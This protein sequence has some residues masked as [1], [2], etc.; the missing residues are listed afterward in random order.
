[1]PG[2]ACCPRACDGLVGWRGARKSGP[3]QGEAAFATL[4]LCEVE[5]GVLHCGLDGGQGFGADAM[6]GEELA[7]GEFGEVLEGGD[8]NVMEGACGGAAEFGEVGHR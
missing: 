7:A 5:T 2:L 1:M 4:F 6:E 8:A 3:S